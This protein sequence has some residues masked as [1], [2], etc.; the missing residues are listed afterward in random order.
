MLLS[1]ALSLC[2]SIANAINDKDI[3]KAINLANAVVLTKQFQPL[4]GKRK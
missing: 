3:V 2:Q 4:K 1:E